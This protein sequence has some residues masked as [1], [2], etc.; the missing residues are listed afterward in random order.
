MDQQ[1]IIR[2]QDGDITREV[3]AARILFGQKDGVWTVGLEIETEMTD[4]EGWPRLHLKDF[5][6]GRE[7]PRTSNQVEIRVPKG[8]DAGTQHTNLYF[9]D[10]CEPNDNVI[11]LSKLAGDEYLVEWTCTASD[12][13]YYDARAQD[14]RIVVRC[15]ATLVARIDYPW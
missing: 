5:P 2:H 8:F 1:F 7:D 10:H 4:E 9:F 15:R 3:S 6:V 11:K 12:V 14:N 13:D